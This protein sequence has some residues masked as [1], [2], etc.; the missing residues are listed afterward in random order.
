MEHCGHVSC[1]CDKSAAYVGFV[2]TISESHQKGKELYGYLLSS[3][4]CNGKYQADCHNGFSHG[5]AYAL[6][7]P[8][9]NWIGPLW[10]PQ[11]FYPLA[12]G[13]L[14]LF[15]N[16]LTL[17]ADCSM[18]LAGGETGTAAI[19]LCQ[20]FKDD[21]GFKSLLAFLKLSNG[22]MV[23]FHDSQLLCSTI[24]AQ[25]NHVTACQ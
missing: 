3:S 7:L 12:C 22:Q 19:F 11:G 25:F 4:M 15:L 24:R 17:M 2:W 8:R 20:S 13:I 10:R 6:L 1:M 5:D 23:W 9:N 16:W 18:P 14:L 21:R